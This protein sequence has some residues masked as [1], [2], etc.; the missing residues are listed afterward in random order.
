MELWFTMEKLWYYEKNYD[1]MEK[2]YG[3]ITST[4]ELRFSKEKKIKVFTKNKDT[5]MDNGKTMEIYQKINVF[6]QIYIFY[7]L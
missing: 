5:L 7:N 4:M 1:T 2:I 6:E 3:T